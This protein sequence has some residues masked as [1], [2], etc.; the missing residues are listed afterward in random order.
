MMTCVWNRDWETSSFCDEW[1]SLAVHVLLAFVCGAWTYRLCCVSVS[2]PPSPL[3]PDVSMPWWQTC[4]FDE[5][6]EEEEDEDSLPDLTSLDA[7]EYTALST[8]SVSAPSPTYYEPD[9]RAIVDDVEDA[10][11]TAASTPDSELAENL[12]AFS[13]YV[14]ASA[15]ESE[16][17][18]DLTE[19]LS[20]SSSSK[21]P[22]S[23]PKSSS[24]LLW[25]WSS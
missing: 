17:P 19:S 10:L 13:L 23:S 2:S 18:G 25:S 20:E 5:D 11:I 3:D 12:K 24:S 21:S 9:E 1:R 16:E 6:E 15:R 14:S 22:N 8:Q 7:E 4:H